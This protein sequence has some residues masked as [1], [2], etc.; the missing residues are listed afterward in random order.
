[1]MSQKRKENQGKKLRRGS[2]E[3]KKEVDGEA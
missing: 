2:C 3:K 1:M